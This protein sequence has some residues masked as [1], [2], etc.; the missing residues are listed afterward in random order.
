MS[1]EYQPPLRFDF[2]LLED[3]VLNE[4]LIGGRKFRVVMDVRVDSE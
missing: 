3:M 4:E 2:C 1:L